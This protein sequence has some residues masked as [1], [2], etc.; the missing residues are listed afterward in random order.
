M[1]PPEARALMSVTE[2]VT[3]LR[4]EPMAP[5]AA[6][7]SLGAVTLTPEL[8]PF[9]MSADWATRCAVWAPPAVLTVTVPRFRV[10]SVSI[11]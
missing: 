11:R 8:S 2:V 1:P 7:H 3:D 6:S 10:P 5:A 9:W 4:S